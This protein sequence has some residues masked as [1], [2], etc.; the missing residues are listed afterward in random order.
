MD[1]ETRKIGMLLAAFEDEH[2]QL[3]RVIEAIARSGAVLQSQVRGAAREAVDAALKELRPQIAQA[4][5]TLKDLERFSLWRAAWQHALISVITIATT[6]LVVWA[7]VPSLSEI[8]AL[9]A[10][11]T[12]LQASID[13]LS[14]RGARMSLMECGAQKRLCVLIDRTAGSFSLPTH[15]EDVYMVAKGY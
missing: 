8:I 13:D 9:R 3:K 7:Y 15:K 2:V 5:Q 6:L 10:E 4:G 14:K 1:D 12:Q 11:N